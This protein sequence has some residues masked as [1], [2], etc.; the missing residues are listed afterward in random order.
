MFVSVCVCVSVSV[1]V[2]VCDPNNTGG[3]GGQ[4]WSGQLSSS[5]ALQAEGKAT[6]YR[7]CVQH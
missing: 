4:L 2:S 6:I 7:V 5:P 3:G 1:C